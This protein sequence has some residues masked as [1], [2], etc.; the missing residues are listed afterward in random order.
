MLRGEYPE[1]LVLAVVLDRETVTIARL[2]ELEV[3]IVID[4]A[5]PFQGRVPHL[6]QAAIEAGCH[7]IDLAD[8]RGRA[9]RN[10]GRRTV[11]ER[12]IRPCAGRLLVL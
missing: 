8:A 2:R 11:G 5:G 9:L 4:A 3:F 7:F 1:A 10:L 6:A 12:T